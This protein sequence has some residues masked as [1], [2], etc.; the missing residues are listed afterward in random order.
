M[1]SSPS[2]QPAGLRYR[3]DLDVLPSTLA[4]T[5][6]ELAPDQ[7]LQGYLDRVRRGH[8]GPMR[9]LLHRWLCTFMSDFD[10]NGLLGMYPMHLISTEQAHGLLG[11]S[12]HGRL[13]DVGAGAGDVTAAL[14]P[15]FADVVT[16]EISWAMAHRLRRRGW[17]AHRIDVASQGAPS[18]PYDVVSCL[19]VLDRC[20]RPRSLLRRCREALAPDGRLLVSLPLPYLPHVYRGGH[21]VAPTEE[22]DVY[23]TNWELGAGFVVERVLEPLGLVAERWS[24]VPYLSGGDSHRPF[25]ELDAA[26]WVCRAEIGSAGGDPERAAAPDGYALAPCANRV[27]PPQSDDS[28]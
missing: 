10:A 26:V 11:A 25:Y 21:T 5:F 14:A 6:V 12:A 9:T 7:A 27:R 13:L 18:P 17:A 19:N 22:L 20:P 23:S 3:C 1:Q 16:T 4:E 15:L 28:S 8:P 24:R 2:R